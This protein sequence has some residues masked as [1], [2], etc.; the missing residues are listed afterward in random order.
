MKTEC[1]PFSQIP[2]TSRLF[3]DFLSHAPAVQPF[4]PCSPG[5]SEWFRNATPNG[6]YDSARRNRITDILD[7]QNKNW[8][9]SG[10]VLDHIARFR[11]GASALLTGQQVGL[12]GGPLFAIFKALTAVKLA[13]EASTKG[14]ETVPIFWLATEDHDLE[15]VNHTVIPGQDGGLET[16][17]S[18]ARGIED[19]P[20]GTVNLGTDVEALV[21]AASS[22]GSSSQ[23]TDWLRQCY[24]SEETFGG[25]F[26]RLFAKIFADWGLILLDGSDPELDQIAEPI[27]RA[28]VDKSAEIGDALLTRGRELDSAGYHQQVKVTSSSTLLFTFVNGARTAIQRRVNS[29][30]TTDFLLGEERVSQGELRQ[31]ISKTAEQFSPN[32]LLRPVVQD[33]LLPTLAYVGGPSEIAY[34]A[35]SAVVYEALLGHVTPIVPRFSA[36][37]VDAKAQRLLG[38]YNL[39]LVDVFHGPELLKQELASRALPADLQ[40]AFD[41]ADKALVACVEAIRGSLA[42]L[43]A[44][45]VDAADRAASKMKYQLEHLRASASRAELRQSELLERH[46]SFLSNLLYPNKTLQEREIAGIYFV[47]RYGPELLHQLYENIHGDCLDHQ[48]LS[49]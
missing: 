48:L 42:R 26:A 10:K 3:T 29:D 25:A 9:A 34:F 6:R 8:N 45:L 24:R 1:L 28:V 2:H 37:L 22:L 7:R 16:L 31:R 35:Q 19:A 18:S 20:V 49:M 14:I 41:K 13:D 5:F 43:D 33:Y 21:E 23:V 12:F 44:T 47:A 39:S 38:K 15:E 17:V 46:A 36:T 4:Y 32:A 11:A 40:T 30:S 27:Y